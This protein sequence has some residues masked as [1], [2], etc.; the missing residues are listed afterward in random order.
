MGGR[1]SPSVRRGL[2]TLKLVQGLVEAPP[3][4]CFVAGEFGE[5]VGL[6]CIPDE[7]SA[8]SSG[9][10][11]LLGLHLLCPGEGFLVL[12]LVGYLLRRSQCVYDAPL[13]GVG[14]LLGP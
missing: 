7:S 14:F 13:V 9:L 11:I 8:E 12:L 5:G 10:R 6:V 1:T 4:R 2:K 3:Y